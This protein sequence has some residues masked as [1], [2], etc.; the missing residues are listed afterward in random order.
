MATPQTF[1]VNTRFRTDVTS[2]NR[3][4]IGEV[5]NQSTGLPDPVYTV[6]FVCPSGLTDPQLLAL[7]E[8]RLRAAFVLPAGM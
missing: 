8:G 5:L 6:T 3:W 4:V 7:A 1:I 2:G